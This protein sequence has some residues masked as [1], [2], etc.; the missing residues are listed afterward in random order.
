[1]EY[2]YR[3]EKN[4]Q[5]QLN[6]R[7]VTIHEQIKTSSTKEVYRV[8]GNFEN[9]EEYIL[10]A[11]YGED[12]EAKNTINLYMDK[13]QNYFMEMVD[14]YSDETKTFLLLKY[15]KEKS[16]FEYIKKN[17]LNNKERDDLIKGI[18]EIGCYLHKKS[19]LHADIK[20]DNFFIDQGGVK[21]GDLESLVE[22]NNLQTDTV[23]TLCG[24]KGFKYSTT[25]TYSLKDELFAYLATIYYIEVGELLIDSTKFIELTST[26]N[27]TEA[28]NKYAQEYITY[29][30]REHIREFLFSIIDALEYQELESNFDCCFLFD[31]FPKEKPKPK[32][33]KLLYAIIG[34]GLILTSIYF[35]FTI[36]NTPRCTEAFFID[37]NTIGVGD[38]FYNYTKDGF[39]PITGKRYSDLVDSKKRIYKTSKGEV[40]ECLNGKVHIF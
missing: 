22:L 30:S 40:I 4:E 39:K 9:R 31:S 24:T 34:I 12:N 36:P 29:I 33:K 35:F 11:I 15:Y 28:I 17:Y 19:Y 37:D 23:Q 1:M 20:P 32:W 14:F 3:Y 5:I 21:L 27:P 16:I 7:T 38:S 6:H 2:K 13:E 10:K 8:I 26:P 18:L 25:S